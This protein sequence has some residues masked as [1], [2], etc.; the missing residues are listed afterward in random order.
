MEIVTVCINKIN[1]KIRG[2]FSMAIG[3]FNMKNGQGQTSSPSLLRLSQSSKAGVV[4]R[5]KAR[6]RLAANHLR[7]CAAL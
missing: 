3:K 2:N 7:A 1:E 4:S 6:E 5:V